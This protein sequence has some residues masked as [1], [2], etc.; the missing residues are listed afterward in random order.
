V[1]YG[2][3]GEGGWQIE[4]VAEGYFYGP[5]DLALDTGDRP[6]I[7]YHDHQGEMF[8][9]N[10]GDAAYAFKN[11]DGWD[12]EAVVHPGHDGWDTSIALGPEGAVHISSID[13]VQ[14]GA[15]DGVEWAVRQSGAWSIRPIGSGPVP[16]EFGTGIAVDGTGRVHLVYHDGEE[17][18]NAT[19]RGSDL[20]YAT[21][22]GAG[23]EIEEVDSEGDVGKFASIAVDGEGR[24][25]LAYFEWTEAGAGYVKYAFRDGEGWRTERVERLED[26]EI[27]FLG[28]R[29]MTSIAMD[30]EGRP[31]MAYADRTWVR[32]AVRSGEAWEIQTVAFPSA[33]SEVLGQL[34][35]LALDRSG[36]PHLVY[37]EL[38]L[39]AATSLGTIF[40]ALGPLPT[41]VLERGGQGAP[42]AFRLEENYPNPFNAGTVLRYTLNENALVELAVYN[43]AGQRVR[44]LAQGFQSAGQ[45]QLSW[46]GLDRTGRPAASGIYLSRLRATDAEAVGKMLL[47]R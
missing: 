27:S 10:T 23:W 38:P 16:Y 15:V 19:G 4:T 37:Y 14:F 2:V 39:R 35:S 26:V 18:L 42:A 21:Y 29:R 12:V 47:I 8:D 11:G 24:P 43:L 9:P 1:F 28:A 13:P 7:V 3:R 46:D 32:C 20:F 41:A 44:T 36:R 40:Y 6:H 31:H 25:H 30:G 5:L 33:G 22:A 17:R 45:H 34:V